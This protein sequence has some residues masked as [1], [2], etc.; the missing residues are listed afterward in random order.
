M[1][2]LKFLRSSIFIIISSII[3]FLPEIIKA[4]QVG[5]EFIQVFPDGEVKELV[6]IEGNTLVSFTKV[7]S[8]ETFS[9]K[10]I[11]VIV[12]AYSSTEGETD[13]D[14][15]ITAAGTQVREGIVANNFLS[16]G[17]KIKIPEI[18]GEKIFVVEDRMHWRKG[19][20]HIDVWFPDYWKAL[21]FG[22][23]RTYIEIV[24]E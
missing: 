12:T 18:F 24:E 17:T 10:K 16:F 8:P 5:V 15:F 14:P 13:S 20:Y 7:E 11:E 6:I 4:P 19:N 22:A 21:N 9:P 3:F 2:T 1:F 23:K